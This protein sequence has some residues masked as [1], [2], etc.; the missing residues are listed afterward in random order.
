MD[1]APVAD[2]DVS[3]SYIHAY[4]RAF[5]ASPKRVGR[6][7]VAWDAGMKEARVA[8][9]VKHWPG[10]GRARDTHSGPARIPALSKLKKSDLLPFEAAF[11]HDV[12]MVMV[13]HLKS[14]GLTGKGLPASES[15]KAMRYLRSRCG[16]ETVIIT[17][18]LSMGAA[19]S[20]LHISAY[21]ASARSIAAGADMALVCTGSAG[22]TV[23]AIE[24]RIDSGRIP[25]AQA[26]ES[27]R[28]ILALKQRLGLVTQ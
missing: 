11:E 19:S 22:K 8:S 28:R 20:A 21:R 17:D 7:V 27:V 12:P 18:S 6:A 25:R 1:F 15:P 26:I 10:H 4:R 9:A 3:G 16:T 2:L 5:S 13:G 24:Q 14:S 23:A